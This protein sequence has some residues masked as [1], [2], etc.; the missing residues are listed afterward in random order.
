MQVPLEIAFVNMDPSEFVEAR[1]RTKAAKLEKRF[2]RLIS[3]RIAIEVPHR[4]QH[5]KGSQYHVRIEMSVPGKDLVISKAPGDIGRHRDVYVAIEDAFDAAER[6]LSE[7]A[8]QMR[9]DVKIHAGPLQGRIL[10]LFPE[11][12]YGFIATHDGREIYFH[13][14]SVVDADFDDLEPEQ[15]VELVV[16]DGESPIGPQASTVRP[17]GEFQYSPMPQK[18]L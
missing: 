16:A 18:P 17:I 9:G 2:P 10:R 11:Q 3:C 7:Y 6:Q 1:V 5:H 8:E 13:R 14:N 4:T 15:T 12:D